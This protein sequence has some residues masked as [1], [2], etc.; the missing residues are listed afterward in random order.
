MSK[1]VSFGFG[2]YVEKNG[3]YFVECKRCYGCGIAGPAHVQ[4]G[5]CFRCQGSGIEP[6]SKAYSAEEAQKRSNRLEKAWNKRE[7]KRVA[8]WEANRAEYE[9]AAEA[10]R[11]A[12][13]EAAA[14]RSASQGAFKYLDAEV[15]EKVVVEGEAVFVKVIEGQYGSSLMVVVKVA[16]DCEV[17]MFSSAAS[18]WAVNKGDRVIISGSVKS[19]E[20]YDGKKQSQ[21]VRVKAEIVSSDV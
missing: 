16:E 7:E 17:K 12:A 21:L 8:E 18:I 6:S 5:I 4:A 13:E 1:S 10:E 19:H 15:G 11:V 9:A 2:S 20:E 3:F 14:A